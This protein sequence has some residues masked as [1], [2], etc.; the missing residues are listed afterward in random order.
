L[1]QNV[2]GEVFSKAAISVL[3]F[4]NAPHEPHGRIWIGVK[5]SSFDRDT[6]MGLFSAWEEGLVPLALSGRNVIASSEKTSP[7]PSHNGWLPCR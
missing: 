5:F 4:L 7:G 6:Y 3:A 1:Y 2:P